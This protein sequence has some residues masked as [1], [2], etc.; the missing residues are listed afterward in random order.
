VLLT[1]VGLTLIIGRPKR[2]Y[3]RAL[4]VFLLILPH[5]FGAPAG[6][7]KSVVPAELSR[8]FTTASLESAL[9]FWITLGIAGGF[10]FS[11]EATQ[12]NPLFD[13]DE[14]LR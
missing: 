3:R 11:R 2:W 8:H 6:A 7:G 5:A 10:I 13:N 12:P 9:L 1:G 14:D 4:G